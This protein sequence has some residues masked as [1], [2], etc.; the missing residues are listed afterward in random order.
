MR[1]AD[2]FAVI[3]P[4]ANHIYKVGILIE[5]HCDL[6]RIPLIPGFGEAGWQVFGVFNRGV[7]II[8]S[9]CISNY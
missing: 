2:I 6:V 3:P 1:L 9:D 7:V 4:N 5:Q 8:H